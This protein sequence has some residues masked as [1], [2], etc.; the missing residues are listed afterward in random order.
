MMLVEGNFVS[1]ARLLLSASVPSFSASCTVQCVT[2]LLDPP[3]LTDRLGRQADPKAP[4]L[5]VV[6]PC[7][8][9]TKRTCTQ[10]V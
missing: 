10:S 5:C 9:C 8:V 1:N 2:P 3:L 6:M 7:F 4:G